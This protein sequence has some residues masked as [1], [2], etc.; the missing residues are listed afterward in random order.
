MSNRGPMAAAVHG[1]HEPHLRAEQGV[2]RGV[3]PRP[4]PAQASPRVGI[5]EGW[6][7]CMAN[8]ITPGLTPVQDRG[9]GENAQTEHGI[10][11]KKIDWR[12]DTRNWE[13]SI[14]AYQPV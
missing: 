7:I 14:S 11:K 2:C 4:R 6:S 1:R 8:T 9:L 10:R 13:L 12:G 3:S 5:G